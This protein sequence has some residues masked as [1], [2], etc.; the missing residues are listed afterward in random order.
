MP[1][2]QWT[3]E[4]EEQSIKSKFKKVAGFD[5]T[6]TKSISET[7]HIKTSSHSCQN[8]L[9]YC[10]VHH[11]L[12]QALRVDFKSCQDLD[13]PSKR[14][15]RSDGKMP[16]SSEVERDR[17]NA[18]T[19]ALRLRQVAKHAISTLTLFVHKNSVNQAE[20]YRLLV[21]G[22]DLMKKMND[23]DYLRLGFATLVCEIL[24]D[25]EELCR[26]VDEKLYV[27][28]AKQ[29]QAAG[30][31]ASR[32][33]YHVA[34]LLIQQHYRAH[35]YVRMAAINMIQSHMRRRNNRIAKDAKRGKH[36]RAS[37]NCQAAILEDYTHLES[38]HTS[39]MSGHG[40]EHAATEGHNGTTRFAAGSAAWQ[41]FEIVCCPNFTPI[42][43]NQKKT[44][45][46]LVRD[47]SAHPDSDI[48]ECVWR[49]SLKKKEK[50]NCSGTGVGKRAG[51]SG[52][53]AIGCSSELPSL[54]EVEFHITLLNS[55]CVLLQGGN[56]SITGGLKPEFP[57]KEMLD[58]YHFADVKAGMA[59]GH[60]NTY[61][62]QA[63]D[64][65]HEP[66]SYQ[67]TVMKLS[68]PE[69]EQWRLSIKV[70]TLYLRVLNLIYF[71]STLSDP[72]IARIKDT[73]NF[74]R[75]FEEPIVDYSFRLAALIAPT[76]EWVVGKDNK[77]RNEE[78][79][80]K[81]QYAHL[82]Q[83]LECIASFYSKC[84]TVDRDMER[85]ATRKLQ[86]AVY[87]I[88]NVSACMRSNGDETLNELVIR[89]MRAL[90]DEGRIPQHLSVDK[91]SNK[92]AGGGLEAVVAMQQMKHALISQKS[93]LQSD[94]DT[95][96]RTLATDTSFKHDVKMEYAK[97]LDIFEDVE[98]MTDPNNH[99]YMGRVTKL[100][101][102]KE[103]WSPEQVEE[104]QNIKN[105]SRSN[106]VTFNMLVQR[107]VKAVTSRIR[108]EDQEISCAVMG[109]LHAMV[110]R[111]VPK[112]EEEYA[113][114]LQHIL[115]LSNDEIQE[116]GNIDMMP[117]GERNKLMVHAIVAGKIVEIKRIQLAR[118]QCKEVLDSAAVLFLMLFL[119]VVNISFNIAAMNDDGNQ[120]V[121][122][123]VDHSMAFIFFTE[124][125]VRCWAYNSTQKFLGDQFNL[126][127]IFV[128]FID[129]VTYSL[130]LFQYLLGDTGAKPSGVAIAKTLRLLRV[131]RVLRLLR[132]G[133]IMAGLSGLKVFT[134]K[135]M[136]LGAMRDYRAK[137]STFLKCGV[138][139]LVV[140]VITHT[141]NDESFHPAV[142]LACA[143]LHA[144]TQE[145]QRAMLGYLMK[146][147]GMDGFY[148]NIHARLRTAAVEA[149][150][151]RKRKKKGLATRNDAS[152]RVA[153]VDMSEVE[154]MLEDAHDQ[155][156]ESGMLQVLRL[157]QL[158]MEGHNSVAQ[159]MMRE[160]EWNPKSY[161][162]VSAV[163][164]LLLAVSKNEQTVKELDSDELKLVTGCMEV[165][166]EATQ[167]PCPLTQELLTK[168][169]VIHACKWILTTEMRHERHPY[170]LDLP[171]IL[172]SRLKALSITLVE[173]VLEARPDMS[174]QHRVREVFDPEVYRKCIID[175][176]A[177]INAFDE[178]LNA[179]NAGMT[180]IEVVGEPI[181]VHTKDAIEQ[182]EIKMLKYTSC[183][184]CLMAPISILIK[185]FRACFGFAFREAKYA[186]NEGGKVL[187]KEAQVLAK[188]AQKGIE[189]GT[190]VLDA[191]HIPHK[192]HSIGHGVQYGMGFGADGFRTG[193]DYISAGIMGPEIEVRKYKLQ[194][195]H[196]VLDRLKRH[197][198]VTPV[199][200]EVRDTVLRDA[201]RAELL[202]AKNGV[203][204]QSFAL[205]IVRMRL[206]SV[207]DEFKE[208]IRPSNVELTDEESSVQKR[209]L[210]HKLIDRI[211]RQNSFLPSCLTG[212]KGEDDSCSDDD[213]DHNGSNDGA[214]PD[215]DQFNILE[216]NEKNHEK[217]Q[218]MLLAIRN[219]INFAEAQRWLCKEVRPVEI[220]WNGRVELVYFICPEE[221]KYLTATS[222]MRLKQEVTIESQER[223]LN[224]FLSKALDLVD[225]M[226]YLNKLKNIK[227]YT[228]L[229]A[230]Y[231]DLRIFTGI[232]AFILNLTIIV[233]AVSEWNHLAGG[234][235][236]Y[237]PALDP[238]A[239][240]ELHSISDKIDA[241][242]AA[243]AGTTP[244]P[245]S[246]PGHTGYVANPEE[247][248][249]EDRIEYFL[250]PGH[251]SVDMFSEFMST[252]VVILLLVMI[253]IFVYAAML[254]YSVLSCAPL[255]AKRLLRESKENK[256]KENSIHNI[257]ASIFVQ[258]LNNKM[259]GDAMV[260][261]P[262]CACIFLYGIVFGIL[263]LRD[264]S[265]EW[266]AFY[267][268][269]LVLIAL[270]Y[271][272]LQRQCWA[273]PTG[274]ILSL[275]YCVV[276]DT[277]TANH[278][279][280]HAAQLGLTL[281][282]TIL[283]HKGYFYFA[284]ALTLDL[285]TSSPRLVNVVRSVTENI[286]DLAVTF[287]LFLVVLY[288][289]SSFGFENFNSQLLMEGEDLEVLMCDT[290]LHC[291]MFFLSDGWRSGDIGSTMIAT[292][293]EEFGDNVYGQRVAYDVFFYIIVGVL[294][295]NIV[296]GII[297]D[298]FGA[299]R[300]AQSER[301]YRLRNECFITGITRQ[302]YESLDLNFDE[303]CSWNDTSTNHV[304]N[305]VYFLQ[306]L[307]NKDKDYFNG[308]ESY[309]WEK[310]E[311]KDFRWIPSDRCWAIQNDGNK[312]GKDQKDERLTKGDIKGMDSKVGNVEQRFG[313]I[314]SK[315]DD[316]GKK[317]E[318]IL[319]QLRPPGQEDEAGTSEPTHLQS[320]TTQ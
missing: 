172:E 11:T 161:D 53:S 266:F 208:L 98:E 136:R 267:Q 48:R 63:V 134:A 17:E 46:L 289:F 36:C 305:Y 102:E 315:F 258:Y 27:I 152:R 120:T 169:K 58:M 291:F 290:M 219:K 196:A 193:A 15:G 121:Y 133:R 66:L 60:T 157:M 229:N 252:K 2:K 238:F 276:Y 9:R 113:L 118:M 5:H 221:C 207:S 150:Q 55:V 141:T 311:A 210:R 199:D 296:T 297:L 265:L 235:N 239:R 205:T 175:R 302:R 95:F 100:L 214:G 67:S 80:E 292:S 310:L 286:K 41:F 72:S 270:Y 85:D 147:P 240:E 137:C 224:E 284:V 144:S 184:P 44:F 74:L 168:T 288:A 191:H 81:E 278:V 163:V 233:S 164:E 94:F 93:K 174:L 230:N 166:V 153:E 195:N 314:E 13:G 319:E 3:D 225:E 156:P 78:Q 8:M 20:I 140:D 111:W 178:A 14:G 26:K 206:A 115:P 97:L 122:Q 28:F 51:N 6:S 52:S 216:S 228:F 154:K 132:V 42:A 91:F 62:K 188:E 146:Q 293:P 82:K 213:D 12:L 277:I 247:Q 282:G 189:Q 79:V 283:G 272:Y 309:V 295:N 148:S 250:M 248:V 21:A 255:I 237:N 316:L 203:M 108:D 198:S 217:T 50:K 244:Y 275:C 61:G 127:D 299:L 65:K 242:G 274:N 215:D 249:T 241:L 173:S 130:L 135:D 280:V 298:T 190:K 43:E 40:F 260:F 103:K 128:V 7:N 257:E 263:A 139:R 64:T 76:T 131:L 92:L 38:N 69:L 180:S 254:A 312:E 104:Y 261:K 227:F 1:V 39:A 125:S 84:I 87:K 220:W 301:D 256:K 107:M 19:S 37:H 116:A 24:R 143:L 23:I 68:P 99:D 160:Q 162:L 279:C 307:H 155:H 151:R 300:E 259:G 57:Y 45:Q 106:K 22:G 236:D 318:L 88:A 165:L 212:E 320:S 96:V 101:R 47:F 202:E 171:S 181:R 158:L 129:V 269:F 56:V 112:S 10:E 34:A 138:A 304:W 317:M 149:A 142:K 16:T 83:M 32:A 253:M 245:N 204:Q 306:Y 268:Y 232:C 273:A 119:V 200:I 110:L 70:K 243:V 303:L 35:M 176:Y 29:Y 281:V 182:V 73:W 183:I 201:V 89:A 71:N 167:G 251:V 211:K 231:Y 18:A 234:E 31:A 187:A 54:S 30:M 145:T 105:E 179:V 246:G 313:Q 218:K 109:L 222:K 86:K 226:T 126:I 197:S 209:D 114:E 186:A 308:A 271:V 194:G 192:R 90:G 4:S 123:I 159:N 49:T 287:G 75:S 170:S 33:K 177:D 77:K 223:K 185:C 59:I 262:L 25:N 117:V 285:L 264:S 124:L 294:L